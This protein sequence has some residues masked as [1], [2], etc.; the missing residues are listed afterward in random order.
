MNLPTNESLG[1]EA[2]A[3]FEK[4]LATEVAIENTQIEDNIKLRSK[5]LYAHINNVE[6][7]TKD[8]TIVIPFQG[9]DTSSFVSGGKRCQCLR[10]PGPVILDIPLQKLAREE[11]TKLYVSNQCAGI[12]PQA[13]WPEISCINVKE[14]SFNIQLLDAHGTTALFGKVTNLHEVDF[15]SIVGRWRDFNFNL[16]NCSPDVIF[17][18]THV[19]ILLTRTGHPYVSVTLKHLQDSRTMAEGDITTEKER[20]LIFSVNGDRHNERLIESNQTLKLDQQKIDLIQDAIESVVITDPEEGDVCCKLLGTNAFRLEEFGDE[21]GLSVLLGSQDTGFVNLNNLHKMMLSV[22]G[23]NLRKVSGSVEPHGD[24][25]QFYQ[26]NIVYA[27]GI[28]LIGSL[29]MAVEIEESQALFLSET[30]LPNVLQHI[31]QD[32]PTPSGLNFPPPITFS[33]RSVHFNK[34]WIPI[35]GK[36]HALLPQL[37]ST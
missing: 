5:S 19:E 33:L 15:N 7:R 4:K 32:E 36:I 14:K 18:P 10:Y 2:F 13:T 3:V 1:A 9:L 31:I 35:L 11:D 6:L 34:S 28:T 20:R 24:Y 22:S 29:D 16:I 25:G 12:F 21:G 37:L 17:T 26:I 23:V 8:G 27:D 30:V